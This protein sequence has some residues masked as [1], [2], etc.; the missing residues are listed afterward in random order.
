MLSLRRICRLTSGMSLR[1]IHVGASP[2]PPNVWNT[3]QGN[4]TRA[5]GQRK[6]G[7][8]IAKMA[9]ADK[10]RMVE[11]LLKEK[12]DFLKEIRSLEGKRPCREGSLEGESQCLER[13]R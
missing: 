12:G 5:V 1:A 3:G 11:L 10:D 7:F 9:L 6:V 8:E 4:T 13:E 2:S